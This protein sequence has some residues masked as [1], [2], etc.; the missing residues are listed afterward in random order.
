VSAIKN[1]PSAVTATLTGP[2]SWASV[3]GPS[4][5]ELPATPVV[6]V[7]GQ[8]VLELAAAIRLRQRVRASYESFTGA[9]TGR[10]LSP[11]AGGDVQA[12]GP[13]EGLTSR[14][15][16]RSADPGLQVSRHLVATAADR[17]PGQRAHSGRAGA[18]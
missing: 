9:L 7:A 18:G 10:E 6:P 15:R 3:A 5:P 1:P 8:A 17:R 2:L 4:S 12:G 11:H 14:L 13:V 16:H